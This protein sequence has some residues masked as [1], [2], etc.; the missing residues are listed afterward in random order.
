MNTSLKSTLLR[1]LAK[2]G[3]LIEKGFTLVELLIVVVI[4]GIL[5]GVALPSLL[6]QRDRAVIAGANASAAAL[7]TSCEIDITNGDDPTAAAGET[8][9]LA[10]L[11]PD[12]AVAAA[13]LGDPE[14]DGRCNVTVSG[15]GTAGDGGAFQAFGAKPP[16]TLGTPSA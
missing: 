15:T 7:I 8:A 11:L 1:R 13:V 10:A 2:K 6:A 5:S 16:A 3:N 12:D 9:R 14:D 4:L